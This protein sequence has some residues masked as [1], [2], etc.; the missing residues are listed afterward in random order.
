MKIAIYEVSSLEDFQ[1][2]MDIRIAVFVEDQNVPIAEE[3]DGKD[4]KC[5]HHLLTVDALPVGT[6]RVHYIG[7][8]AKIERVAI[9][10]DYQGAGLGKKL[11]EYIIAGLHSDKKVEKAKLSS[12]I[13]AIPFYKSFG[14]TVCSEEYT[15]A[16]IPHKDMQLML[17]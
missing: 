13:Y 16:G 3:A 11:M 6:A 9:L 5:K 7:N 2:C 14:F 15:D 10:K 8:V 1:K 4:S 17:D 12:Q